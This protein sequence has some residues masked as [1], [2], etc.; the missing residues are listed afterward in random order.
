MSLSE[1]HE[2]FTDPITYTILALCALLMGMSKMGFPGCNILTTSII[3]YLTDV[4]TAITM[5]LLLL[6]PSDIVAVLNFRQYFNKKIFMNFIPWATFGV[7]CSG[8]IAMFLPTKIFIFIVSM[9]ISSFA[10]ILIVQEIMQ[11]RGSKKSL[12]SIEHKK[13]EIDTTK[14]SKESLF[15]KIALPFFAFLSGSASMLANASGPLTSLYLMMSKL[16]KNQFIG[17]GTFLYFTYNTL[18]LLILIFLWQTATLPLVLYLLTLVPWSISGSYLAK[19]ISARM[20]ERVYKRIIIILIAIA[21]IMLVR[22][23]F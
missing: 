10:I 21:A 6:Y 2:L 7:V 4:R 12:S 20:S 17:T 1:I 18:K 14:D 3:V 11:A 19:A 9:F 23:L 5:G 13:Q 15:K 16:P 22:L 8:I